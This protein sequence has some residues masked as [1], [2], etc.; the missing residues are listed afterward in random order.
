MYAIRSY[1]VEEFLEGFHAG[2][3]R[4][5]D[6]RVARGAKACTDKY[7]GVWQS[8]PQEDIP[9]RLDELP[10]GDDVVL[11]CNSGVRSYDSQCFLI[12]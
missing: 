1:Y 10:T 11:F 2:K 7:P 6:T 9:N 8:F 12:V 5:V 4:V 3:Y